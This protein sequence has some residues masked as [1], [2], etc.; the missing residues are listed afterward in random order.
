MKR[1]VFLTTLSVL[2]TVSLTITQPVYAQ[3]LR[4][5]RERKCDVVQKK[6]EQRVATY[7]EHRD[8]HIEKYETV[9]DRIKNIISKFNDKGYDTS[10]LEADLVVL[11]GKIKKFQSDADAFFI[12][13]EGANDYVCG[14]SEGKFRSGIREARD[15]LKVVREDAQDIKS[16]YQTTIKEDLENLRNQ[17][18]PTSSPL[19]VTE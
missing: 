14:D 18:K 10:E 7:R 15:L 1:L 16:Y 6:L 11:D 8:D 9:K 19:T 4:P 2:A 5:V 12:K 17:P 13:L 3:T